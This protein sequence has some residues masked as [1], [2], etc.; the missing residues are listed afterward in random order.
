[1]AGAV[2]AFEGCD[3]PRRNGTQVLCGTHYRQKV[4]GQPLRPFRQMR[5]SA[6]VE[7]E[8][9]RG[10]RTCCDCKTQRPVSDF[11]KSDTHGRGLASTCK[12]CGLSRRR[13]NKYGITTPEWEAMFD[14]QGRVCAICAAATSGG[15]G[16]HT[17]H[18][19]QT[20]GVRGILCAN[21]NLKLGHFEKWYLPHR[22]AVDSYL[23]PKAEV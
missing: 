6:E 23:N 11:H 13:R 4:R 16:W 22:A 12:T 9:E 21:C 5:S 15:S 2:C 7:A 14:R 18:D 1:M 19:H 17:D 8:L 20:E 10:L 3:R